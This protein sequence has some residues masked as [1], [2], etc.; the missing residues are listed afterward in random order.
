MYGP[1]SKDFLNA[2]TYLI[3]VDG[4][5]LELIKKVED[6]QKGNVVPNDSNAFLISLEN[7]LQILG[8]IGPRKPSAV[9]TGAKP[10]Y[11]RDE[12]KLWNKLGLLE[13]K[14]KTQYFFPNEG[15]H[16]DWHVITEALIEGQ[17]IL[18]E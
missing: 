15:Y 6:F 18:S 4:K 5:H 8:C 3:L 10:S 13:M 2:L 16:F 11:V 9:K 14:G 1:D 12:P 17:R 7:Y